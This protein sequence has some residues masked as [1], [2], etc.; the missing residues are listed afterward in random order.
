[1]S[2]SSILHV[3]AAVACLADILPSALGTG[4]HPGSETSMGL[5]G[6][7]KNFPEEF[8]PSHYLVW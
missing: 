2:N 7:E 5:P 4:C 3:N 8:R 1:M 6:R